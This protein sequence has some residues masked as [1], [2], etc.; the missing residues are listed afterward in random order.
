MIEAWLNERGYYVKTPKGE[1]TFV[2]D[3]PHDIQHDASA[4][5]MF[6]WVVFN[7]ALESLSECENPQGHELVLHLDS[8]LVEEIN[9]D[10]APDHPFAKSSLQYFLL[11]DSRKF[12][13]VDCRKCTSS[14]INSRLRLNGQSLSTTEGLG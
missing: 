4:L 12:K 7:Q 13:R 6:R 10:I 3:V 9:G 14:A 2:Y 5:Y 8:R 1:S 11:V